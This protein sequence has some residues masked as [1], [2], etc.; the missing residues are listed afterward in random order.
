MR[1]YN[2]VD[3]AERQNFINAP[4]KVCRPE[5]SETHTGFGGIDYRVHLIL[6]Q[7]FPS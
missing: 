6:R 2:S 5:K 3:P 1:D 7:E 4:K